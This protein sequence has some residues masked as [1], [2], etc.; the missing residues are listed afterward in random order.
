MSKGRLEAFSDAVIA[1]AITIMVLELVPPRGDTL[2][3]LVTVWPTFLAYVISFIYL[4]LFWNNHHHL[5]QAASVISG[6]VLLANLFLLF[7]LSLVPFGSAW[8]GQT[9]F[10]SVPL[11][12][13][14][15]DLLM[16]G[17][18]YFLLVR[19]LLACQPAGSKLAEA[20]GSD[21]KG[22]LSLIFYFVGILVAFPAP[23]VAIALYVLVAAIWFIP[24]RRMEQIVG[25]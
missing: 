18:A 23:P 8:I 14:G 24:D 17:F 16:A 6:R 22:K 21:V 7:W 19:A 20:I 1:I 4:G 10:A 3:D 12:V 2:A 15:F 25:R 13:Y 9:G 11:A 5:L